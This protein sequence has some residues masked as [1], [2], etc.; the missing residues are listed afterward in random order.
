MYILSPGHCIMGWRRTSALVVILV[1]LLFTLQGESIPPARA[2]NIQ[3]EMLT[4]GRE[5]NLG[6]WVIGAL[7][8][9]V[10][11]LV[12]QSA[13]GLDDARA[14]DLVRAYLRDADRIGELED[15]LTRAFSVSKEAATQAE[16]L[17]IREELAQLR[18]EQESRRPQV[19][20]VLER[21]VSA[22]LAAEGLTAFGLVWPP[23]KFHFSEPPLYLIVSPR[24]AIS[25]KTGLHLRPDLDVAQ[26]EELENRVDNQLGVSSLVEGLGGFGVYPAMILDRASLEWI[27]STI[28]HEW[29]HNHLVFRPLGWHYFDNSGTTTLNE[30]V[31]SI[32]GDEIGA[33][34]LATYYPDLVPP[35]PAPRADSVPTPRAA[36]AFN[37]AATMRETRLRV[38]ELLKEGKVEEAEAYMEAQ[39]QL[40]VAQGYPI[41]KLNQAYFAFHGSYATGPGAVDPTGPKLMRLRRASSSLKAFFDV[42]GSLTSIADLD[43]ALTEM[44]GSK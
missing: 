8:N 26:Q 7:G 3:V 37:F 2:F 28:A 16:T 19:E 36:P 14:T 4:A 10:E 32:V 6:G 12:A 25:L 24:E 41:R 40:F 38:D 15:R 30:T 39:R 9:K 1:S 42:A 13:R 34:V 29:V 27:L 18:R 21:Q 23:V 20:A 17:S 44:E 33:R 35:P 5:F 43:I 11:A 31:A 22:A